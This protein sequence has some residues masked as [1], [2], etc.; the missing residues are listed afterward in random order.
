V[1]GVASRGDLDCEI[2]VYGDVS[3]WAP[4]I[5]DTALDAAELGGYEPAAWTSGPEVPAPSPERGSSGNLSG[6]SATGCSLGSPTP[7]HSGNVLWASLLVPCLA[8]MR[9]RGSRRA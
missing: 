8:W 6:D 7:G 5:I 2:A 4:F 3:S 1:I 9:R